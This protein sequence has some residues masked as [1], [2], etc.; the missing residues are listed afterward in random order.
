MNIKKLGTKTSCVMIINFALP[1]QTEGLA[2]LRNFS[3]CVAN[4]VKTS[5]Y[6]AHGGSDINNRYLLPSRRS[7]HLLA[8]RRKKRNAP[9][10]SHPDEDDGDDDSPMMVDQPPSRQ[11]ASNDNYN[12]SSATRTS[13]E[14]DTIRIRIWKALYSANG[15][16][17]SLQQLGN[18]VGERNMGDLNSH[19][20]HVERQAKTIRNKSDEWKKRRGLV[21]FNCNNEDSSVKV[22][23]KV[24]LKRRRGDRGI[25]FIRLQT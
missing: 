24:K 11:A 14:N 16:E 19:L 2:I 5:S 6:L 22:I 18:M 10:S 13:I 9:Y 4:T 1:S 21:L 25:T 15:S 23:D 12:N 8:K 7:T 20:T 17:I 3:G